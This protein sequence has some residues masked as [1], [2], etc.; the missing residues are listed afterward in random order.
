MSENFS[1]LV[2]LINNSVLLLFMSEKTVLLNGNK[3]N[4]IRFSARNQNNKKLILILITV[5]ETETGGL[6]IFTKVFG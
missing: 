4:S 2:K 1:G 5:L 6:V 3:W